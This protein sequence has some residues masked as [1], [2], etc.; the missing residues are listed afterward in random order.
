MEC[1]F[2]DTQQDHRQNEFHAP[3]SSSS[4]AWW[5]KEEVPITW[6]AVLR[7]HRTMYLAATTFSSIQ[8][9]WNIVIFHLT[10]SPYRLFWLATDNPLISPTQKVEIS[11]LMMMK[12][13]D[14]DLA[15]ASTFHGGICSP[16]ITYAKLGWCS[17]IT[18]SIDQDIATKLRLFFLMRILWWWC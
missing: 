9:P 7:W 8:H 18:G 14:G 13:P 16:A 17:S 4:L 6:A 11:S 1:I 3:W 5:M 12:H 2:V 15:G 10:I